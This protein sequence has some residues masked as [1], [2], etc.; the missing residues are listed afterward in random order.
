LLYIAAVRAL[1]AAIKGRL[2]GWGKLI[3]TGSVA[4]PSAR[5]LGV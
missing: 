3:R 5:P 2:V 4:L 1:L